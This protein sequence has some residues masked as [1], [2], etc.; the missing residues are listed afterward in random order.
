[1]ISFRL[2]CRCEISWAS[3]RGRNLSWVPTPLFRFFDLNLKKLIFVF[4]RVTNI[5]FA[6][7]RKLTTKKCKHG[8]ASKGLCWMMLIDWS[9][10]NGH[11]R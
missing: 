3:Q 4:C 7:E 2:Y 9:F 1:M 6:A 11:W 8:S 10:L 5:V